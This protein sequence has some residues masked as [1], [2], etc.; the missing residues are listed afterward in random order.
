[1]SETNATIAARIA[2]RLKENQELFFSDD[3]LRDLVT[4]AIDDIFF[5]DRE[6]KNGYSTEKRP[7]WFKELV[8]EQIELNVRVAVKEYLVKNND[9]IQQAVAD[10]ITADGPRLLAALL[11]SSF[12][13]LGNAIS[14]NVFNDM[15]SSLQRRMS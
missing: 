6:T 1:M 4:A 9:K 8:K 12:T 13:G 10:Q 11:L 14:M 5:K 3:V 15:Q 7:S 2:E